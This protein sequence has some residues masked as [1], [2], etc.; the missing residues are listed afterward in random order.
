[1]TIIDQPILFGLTAVVLCAFGLFLLRRYATNRWLRRIGSVSAG[2]L[3]LASGSLVAWG[4][5]MTSGDSSPAMEQLAPNLTY[6]RLAVGDSAVGH[7]VTID[8][9][10]SCTAL[11]TTELA[12]TGDVDALLTETWVEQQ[13]A[14]LGMNASFFAPYYDDQP[15]DVYPKEGDSVRILGGSVVDGEARGMPR[16]WQGMWAGEYVF[17]DS[18]GVPGVAF[19]APEDAIWGVGG[20]ERILA[21]GEVVAS[22]SDPYPRSI[23]GVDALS[24][25]MW[26]L[27]VDG[28][29]PGYSG[30]ATL[31]QAA[32][33]LRRLGATDALEM[34]GGGSSILVDG[35]NGEPEVLSRPVNQA[36]PGRSRVV[37]NHVGVVDACN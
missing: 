25:T 27:V 13:N 5:W 4:V 3:I 31:E 6:E 23:I 33:L 11:I 20:R 16:D 14:Q 8:L 15:W 7:V 35:T 26:W 21:E 12:P 10:D 29:Q 1:M 9:S 34:D 37:A 24:N 17:L 28:K 36:I 22:D 19:D 18:N 30:G 2:F 32:E